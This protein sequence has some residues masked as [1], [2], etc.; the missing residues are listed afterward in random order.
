MIRKAKAVWRGADNQTDDF[1]DQA[2]MTEGVG[3]S[4]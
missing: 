2:F 1:V 3:I 4:T